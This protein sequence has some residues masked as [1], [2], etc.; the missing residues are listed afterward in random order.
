MIFQGFYNPIF[1]RI[2]ETIN[3][4]LTLFESKVLF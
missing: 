2:T 3:S 4:A 1:L